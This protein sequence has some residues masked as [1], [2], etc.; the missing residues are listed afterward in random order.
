VST[1]YYRGPDA[2]VTGE[3]FVWRG[4]TN[5][6][7]A[8]SDLR[9][10]VLVDQPAEFSGPLKFGVVIA[11]ALPAVG[12]FVGAGPST[13][14]SV[15]AAVVIAGAVVIGRRMATPS[16]EVRAVYLGAEVTIYSSGNERVFNQVVRALR[17]SVESSRPR[18]RDYRLT[19]A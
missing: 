15:L 9:N 16:R 7:F 1:V 2:L 13:V 12:W 6:I 3:R 10:I 8:I 19:A 5:Y 18:T 4:S 17:R 11:A 14:V